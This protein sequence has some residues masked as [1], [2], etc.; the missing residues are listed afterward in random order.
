MLTWI[1]VS[2]CRSSH[3]GDPRLPSARR[4]AQV[5]SATAL[6]LHLAAPARDGHLLFLRS[7]ATTS[8]LPV[9]PGTTRRG[10]S[11]STQL[12][13][14]RRRASA[15]RWCCCTVLLCPSVSPS[16]G[17]RQGNSKGYFALFLLPAATV[18]LVGVFRR[19]RLLPLSTS[20]GSA[21]CGP[22]V[23][24]HRIGRPRASTP[25]SVLSSTT[26]A[27]SVLILIRCSSSTVPTPHTFDM[28][29]LSGA[30]RDD[31]D[32]VRVPLGTRRG[33]T[34]C[35]AALVHRFAI[36]IPGLPFH[37]GSRRPAPRRRRRFLGTSPRAP[38]RARTASDGSITAGCPGRPTR[39]IS[40]SSPR[41][42]TRLKARA[43]PCAMARKESERTRLV[44]EQQ[45]MG[46]VMLAWRPSR[47]G[48]QRRAG[49]CRIPPRHRDAMLCPLRRRPSTNA[50]IAPRQSKASAAAA[51][52]S[53]VTPRHP[54]AFLR[55][56]GPAVVVG[57][58]L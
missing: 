52:I 25:R 19:P 27:L 49:G 40:G 46:Y 7:I 58:S 12:F 11:S 3:G 51:G 54:P 42:A 37:T 16:W 55:R 57:V 47:R 4:R 43:L 22:D 30:G 29:Q 26:L 31:L 34:P 41:S 6:G 36:K 18:R 9:S 50:P 33:S 10:S 48:D 56:D 15:G 38:Q 13:G 8:A 24:H 28:T 14:R 1:D 32:Q 35:G 39:A 23:L 21:C 20:S 53:P 5:K 44:L 17:I 2:L 45:P